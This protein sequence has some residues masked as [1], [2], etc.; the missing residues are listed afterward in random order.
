MKKIILIHGMSAPLDECFGLKVKERLKNNGFEIIE[1][2]FP[3]EKDITLDKWFDVMKSFEKD[4][5]EHTYYLCHSLGCWF[6]LKYLYKTQKKCDTIITVAGGVINHEKTK[7]INENTV[8]FIPTEEEFE[9]IKNNSKRI[10]AIYSN[11]DHI[12]SQKELE[13][14]AKKTMATKIFLE[15]CGHF[16]RSSNV[17]DISEIEEIIKN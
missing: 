14:Y 13:L 7:N 17:K 10:F 8:E 4:V 3:V 15:N 12:F 16:G 11:N 1:P 5:D 2:I 9:Y 6:L